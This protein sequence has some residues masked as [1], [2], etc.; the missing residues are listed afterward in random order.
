[1]QQTNGIP[2]SFHCFFLF[3]STRLDFSPATRNPLPFDAPSD[4]TATAI[5]KLKGRRNTAAVWFS[6][7]NHLVFI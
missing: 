4:P 5:L 7:F 3:H 2:T 1:M 6:H